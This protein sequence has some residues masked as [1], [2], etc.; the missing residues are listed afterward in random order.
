MEAVTTYDKSIMPIQ[1]DQV[2]QSFLLRCWLV[3]PETAEALPVWRFELQEVSDELR[4]HR[5]SDFEQLQAFV[6]A[7]LTAVAKANRGDAENKPDS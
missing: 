5:F 6:A 1:T 2:Y 7:E 3:S 4:R